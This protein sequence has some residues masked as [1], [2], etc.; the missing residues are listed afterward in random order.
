MTKQ[1]F[2]QQMVLAYMKHHGYPPT[3]RHIDEYGEIFQSIKRQHP[4]GQL[5]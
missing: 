1:E 3:D 2:V 4:V 5:Q